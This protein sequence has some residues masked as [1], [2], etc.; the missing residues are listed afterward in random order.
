MKAFAY[1]SPR[2]LDEAL[3]LLAADGG[4]GH[5]GAA[6]RALAGGTDLLTLLKADLLA[7]RQLVDIK[8]LPELDDSIVDGPDGLTIGALATLTQLEEDP[9]IEARYPVLRQA[10]AL[11]ATPQLRNM[12]TIGGNLL[13]R[14]RCWYFRHPGVQCWLKGGD[15]CPARDGENQHHALFLH[16]I[17]PC[18]AVHPSD[19]AAALLALDAV[20]RLRDADGER[21]LPLADVFAPPTEE[22]RL[23]TTLAGKEVIIALRIP[24][25]SADARSTYLKAMERK[26]WAFALVGVAAVLHVEEGRVA[27]ARIVLSGVAPVPWRAI[28][29][30]KAI[31]GAEPSEEVVTRAADIALDGAL[32]LANNGYKIP[33]AKALIRRALSRLALPAIASAGTHPGLLPP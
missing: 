21:E 12:A 19:P 29:A 8:R 27:D 14:P 1:A 30:E 4:Q 9:F 3:G 31:V 2:S 7:P 24:P 20:V 22:R 18:V 25:L 23:E 33:L 10:A 17:S 6:A 28:A 16:D 11:A 15:D 32:P 5:D 13:Q 26:V